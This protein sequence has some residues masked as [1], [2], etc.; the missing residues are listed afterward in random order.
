MSSKSYDPGDS[1]LKFVD[2]ED[3]LDFLCEG[4]ESPR[5]LMSCGHAV[6][7]MSLTKWCRRLLDEGKSRF[8]C[9]QM[10]CEVEWSY[11]EVCKMA[12]LTPEE[13]KYFEKTMA[14]NSLRTYFDTKKCPGCKS[15]VVRKNENNLNVCCKVCEANKGKTYEFCWQCLKEWKRP[16]LQS[17]RC[18][19]DGC[20]NEALKILKNCPV[21]AFES[22]KG[23]NDC[24]SIRACP[25]CGTL[26]KHSTKKCKNI[27]CQGCKVEFCFV[28]LKTT[29]ECLELK[30]HSY[31]AQCS[32]DVAPRQT[33]IP[34]QKK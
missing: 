28:C 5:A 24:P 27:V 23:V 3:E 15:S 13:K 26:V 2:R 34:V 10:N 18:D 21:M 1:T 9:G 8:V 25:T 33:S 6:T 20:A 19:N 12:L 11:E 4:F 29:K 17:D 14:S 32:S 7:L 16:R 31:F 22:V 30:P